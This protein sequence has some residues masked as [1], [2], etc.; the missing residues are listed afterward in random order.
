MEVST[1]RQA[2][3]INKN[4]TNRSLWVI[5]LTVQSDFHIPNVFEP[6]RVYVMSFKV[7]KDINSF[8]V[9]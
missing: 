1:A 8:S 7:T 4:S 3:E 5:R 2:P 9:Y 6:E